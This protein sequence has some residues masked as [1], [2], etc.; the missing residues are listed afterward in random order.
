[1]TTE[2]HQ[3]TYS[4]PD[5]DT[6]SPP[7]QELKREITEFVKM[8]VWFLIIF[9]AV[10]RF[11][12]EGYEVQG[13]S[14]IPT[15]HDR[16]R[17]LVFKLP[18]ELS[19]L[20]GG[21]EA[22]KPGDIVVF[23]STDEPGKRYVKRIIAEGPLRRAGNT[24]DASR[25]NGGVT[26]GAVRVQVADG[27]VYVNNKRLTEKYVNPNEPPSHETYRAVTLGPGKYYVMGDNRDISKDSRFFGAVDDRQI[28]GRAVLRFWPLSKFG[29]L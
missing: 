1:M 21:F 17:I 29:L 27:H 2:P 23:R 13:P 10:R 20:F 18:H 4:S 19:R 22:L 14:M 6:N 7:R 5:P 12:I 3:D 25:Q 15:L 16:E 11:V 9:F 28:V 8:V 26:P 24:V